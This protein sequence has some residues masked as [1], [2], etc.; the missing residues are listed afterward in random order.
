MLCIQTIKVKTV[1]ER[2]WQ[3]EW[4]AAT[5]KEINDK[6]LQT[7]LYPHKHTLCFLCVFIFNKNSVDCQWFCGFGETLLVKKQP[8]WC[9]VLNILS[10]NLWGENRCGWMEVCVCSWMDA[11]QGQR[12]NYKVGIAG[13]SAGIG[14]LA[15]THHWK[16]MPLAPY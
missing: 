15:N 4:V 3:T 6:T 14:H 13:E 5:L 11:Y 8:S 9:S 7:R 16:Q 2:I 10:M 12:V 1:A